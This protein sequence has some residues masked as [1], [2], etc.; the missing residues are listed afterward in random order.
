MED[1]VYWKEFINKSYKYIEKF[2]VWKWGEILDIEIKII[3]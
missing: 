1:N 3:K 2:K